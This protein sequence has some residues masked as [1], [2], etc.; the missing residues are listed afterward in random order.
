M[1]ITWNS[2][3]FFDRKILHDFL[4]FVFSQNF[5]KNVTWQGLIF[6]K[7]QIKREHCE[8]KG[9]LPKIFMFLGP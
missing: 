5:T 9:W 2:F 7:L 1:A 6:S 8:E 4:V 3:F